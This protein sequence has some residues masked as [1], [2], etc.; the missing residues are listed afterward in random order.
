MSFGRPDGD[1]RP[2]AGRRVGVVERRQPRFRIEE[3][4]FDEIE[5]MRQVRLVLALGE[6]TERRGDLVKAER[7]GLEMIVETMPIPSGWG[8]S[9]S[10]THRLC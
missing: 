4:L 1:V 5:R 2:P 10:P 6:K 9:A 8:R 3:A 7:D